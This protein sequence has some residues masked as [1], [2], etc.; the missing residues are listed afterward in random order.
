MVCMKCQSHRMRRIKREGFVRVWLAPVFG[1]FP[2]RCSVCRSEQLLKAR[3]YRKQTVDSEI[4]R[5]ESPRHSER[6]AIR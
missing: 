2:W 5:E 3:S 4:Q 6:Q 1:Y